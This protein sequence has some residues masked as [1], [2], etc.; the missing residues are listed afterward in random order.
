M[1]DTCIK[2]QIDYREK[3]FYETFKNAELPTE[4]VLE[5]PIN[6]DIGDIIINVCGAE[7]V[8]QQIIIERKRFD[9]LASSI[10]DG[11]YDE[12]KMRCM[13]YIASERESGRECMLM[14]LL[15]GDLSYCRNSN[16]VNMA[17]GAWIS[18]EM[19]DRVPVIRVLNM[20]EGVKWLGRLCER[21]K[22]K[23]GEIFKGVKP[24]Q[25]NVSGSNLEVKTIYLGGGAH[26]SASD[27]N[28]T[29]ES[30]DNIK[31]VTQSEYLGTIKTK[32]KENITPETCAQV[33]LAV[34]PGMTSDTAK[35][36]LDTCGGGT[37]VGLIG[38]LSV[39][40]NVAGPERDV[41]IKEKK[42]A[43]SAIQVKPG[44]KLGPALAEKIWDYLFA[45]T[46]K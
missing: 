13:S 6:L 40:E 9:D 37:L 29:A 15:E 42:K 17:L 32:K 44:R 2:I 4:C 28:T 3:D 19:R 36:V 27:I 25:I 38:A 33:M 12:Q 46:I 26:G 1:G 35:I 23:P 43:L 31:Q 45:N 8:K 20:D 34:I 30:G 18:M 7:S 39:G 16:D 14:Y 41:A 22:K 24:L 10:K 21:I 11:R 5:E